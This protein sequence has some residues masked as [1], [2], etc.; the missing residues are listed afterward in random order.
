MLREVRK[1]KNIAKQ[2]T[3]RSALFNGKIK[4]Y[5]VNG[6]VCYDVAEYDDYKKKAKVGR[7]VKED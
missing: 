7:P 1:V 5:V 2:S 3:I 4:R 6:R